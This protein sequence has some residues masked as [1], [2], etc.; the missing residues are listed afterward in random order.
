MNQNGRYL[1]DTNIV[2]ALFS[3]ETEVQEKAQN[4]GVVALAPP[5]EQSLG[6]SSQNRQFCATK[7]FFPLRFGDSWV[8]WNH[9][10]P[11]TEERQPYP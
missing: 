1:L 8:V 4:A 5:I 6:K 10:R 2:I 9:Q 3:E 11:V 7:R